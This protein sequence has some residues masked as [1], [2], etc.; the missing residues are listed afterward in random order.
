LVYVPKK[1][2]KK[3][4]ADDNSNE[5]E[6]E[7]SSKKKKKKKK[8][9]KKEEEE[10]KKKAEA[11]KIAQAAIEEEQQKKLKEQQ[12]QQQ[13]QQE[14]QQEKQKQQNVLYLPGMEDEFGGTISPKTN[15]ASSSSTSE[16]TEGTIDIDLSSP[17]VTATSEI[18]SPTVT[19]TSPTSTTVDSMLDTPNRRGLL[20]GLVEQFAV[21]FSEVLNP[22]NPKALKKV[23]V[24]TGLDLDAQINEPEEDSE[25]DEEADDGYSLEVKDD[26]VEVVPKKPLTKQEK[27]EAKERMRKEQVRKDHDPF[28]IKDTKP[29]IN[30]DINV[31]DIPE[32]HLDKSELPDLKMEKKI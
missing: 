26:E 27:E 12:Q 5:D 15:N 25:P 13:Q 9:E 4:K 19:L 8:K 3:K 23:P 29:L 17:V 16:H 28:Y 1:K 30:K 7:N 10:K 20:T 32:K 18:T 11:D 24:P 2:K 21:L 6:E 14:Q 31:D 22:V